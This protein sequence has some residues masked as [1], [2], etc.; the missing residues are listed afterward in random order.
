MQGRLG[1]LMHWPPPQPPHQAQPAGGLAALSSPVMQLTSCSS[2]SR[3]IV[4]VVMKLFLFP[5]LPQLQLTAMELDCDILSVRIGVCTTTQALV[6]SCY[7]GFAALRHSAAGTKCPQ[8]KSCCS[9]TCTC[10]H[11]CAAARISTPGHSMFA[12]HS[13]RI[14]SEYATAALS[15]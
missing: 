14:M 4:L 12:T 10:P 11:C 5:F 13:S 8:Q 6:S 2:V 15:S 3:N 1:L 9:C 7:Q